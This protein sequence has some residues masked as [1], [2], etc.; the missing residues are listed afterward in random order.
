MKNGRLTALFWLLCT[1]GLA[2][3]S[4]QAKVPAGMSDLKV[5]LVSAL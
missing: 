1:V 5:V 3:W 2:S 4:E